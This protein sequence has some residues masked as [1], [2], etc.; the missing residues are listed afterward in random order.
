MISSDNNNLFA[1]RW[2]IAAG[3]F[4]ALIVVNGS[5][6]VFSFGF[7]IKPLEAEFGWDRGSISIGLALCA[8]C[9]AISLPIAGGLMDKYGVRP[10]MLTSIV[11]FAA[12]IAAI[13]LSNVLVVF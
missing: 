6:S 2:W 4:L 1:S 3:S 12:N 5:I 7:F 13:S 10:V 11:L 9:S 8:L